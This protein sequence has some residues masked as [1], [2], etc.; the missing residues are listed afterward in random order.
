M[1]RAPLSGS[2]ALILVARLAGTALAMHHPGWDPSVGY[3][4][5]HVAEGLGKAEK[6]GGKEAPKAFAPAVGKGAE[7]SAPAS[8]RWEPGG[9]WQPY[10]HPQ[11]VGN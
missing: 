3:N 11:P 8:G 10:Q 2:L 6:E 4:P 1:L 5:G 7:K 9:A